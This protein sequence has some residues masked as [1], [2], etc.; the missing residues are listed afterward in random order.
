MPSLIIVE[1]IVGHT[2]MAIG[3]RSI[4]EYVTVLVDG[5]ANVYPATG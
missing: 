4:E 5:I 1:P 3:L 2:A